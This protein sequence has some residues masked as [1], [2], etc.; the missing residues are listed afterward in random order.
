VVAYHDYSGDGRTIV[1]NAHVVRGALEAHNHGH[2]PV[3][4]GEYGIE[5]A[6]LADVRQQALMRSALTG[7]APIGLAAW[8]SLRDDFPMTCCPP[9]AVKSEYY[10]LLTHA[11]VE[12]QGYQTMRQL[13]AS[14]RAPR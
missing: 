10:G 2:K 3:W 8:Y 7:N 9:R 4:I 6:E 1:Q 13:L 11:Y 5:E 14:R 12:K